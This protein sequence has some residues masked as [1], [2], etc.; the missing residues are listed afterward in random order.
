MNKVNVIIPMSGQSRRFNDAGY[1]GPKALLNVGENSMIEHIVNMFD[2]T[3]CHY[4]I[5]INNDQLDSNSNLISDLKQLALNV[6]VI[7]IDSHELGPVYSILQVNNINSDEDIIISYCDFIVEWNYLSFLRHAQ[8]NDGCIVSF[9][10]FHPA[11]FGNTYYAY[12]RVRDGKML[13]LREKKSFTNNRSEEHASAGIYY[14]KNYKIFKEYAEECLIKEN[15]PLPESYVSLLYNDMV[16]D[17]L[18]VTVYEANKFICLGTPEDYEQYQFW[19]DFFTKKQKSKIENTLNIKRIGLIPMAG[20]GSRF[21]DYGYRVAKPLIKISGTPMVIRTAESIPKQDKWIFLPRQEDIDRHPI[22]KALKKFNSECVIKPVKFVTTGQA[23]TCILAENYIDN[24]AE[25]I[26]ASSDYEHRYSSSL[27]QSILKDKTID[28]AIWTYR[29]RSMALKNPENFAYCRLRDD[30]LT[31][32]SVVEKQTISDKPHLDPLVV[33]TFWYRK[34]EDFK[35]AAHHLIENNITVNGEHYVGTSINYLI[36]KGRRFIIFDIEQ[37]IS[38][39]DPFEL[40]ILE[41]W[42][43]YFQ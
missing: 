6:E 1:V 9:K 13:E 8:G 30:G 36:K 28:G 17:K 40:K 3:F 4:H 14:F 7:L 5:I 22:E 33:G 39:G 12:M 43:E 23:A 15:K 19:W 2:P 35:E 26:I 42:G 34:A 37:W 18:L 32:D 10:G 41:Y 25:L 29:C 24:D 21:Q 11:S 38:F 20:K 27:W 31:I 16:R